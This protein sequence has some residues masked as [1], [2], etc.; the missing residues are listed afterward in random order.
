MDTKD[1][2]RSYTAPAHRALTDLSIPQD[3]REEVARLY[4]YD[5]ID[6]LD[7]SGSAQYQP[8][9]TSVKLQQTIESYLIDQCHCDQVETY[10]RVDDRLADRFALD[11]IA[12]PTL[13]N[14]VAPEKSHLRSTLLTGLYEVVARNFRQDD[15]IQICEIAKV[16]HGQTELTALGLMIYRKSADQR[17][18]D[19]RLQLKGIV[20]GLCTHADMIDISYQASHLSIAHPY[21]QADII[22]SGN[23]IG[24]LYQ[25]HPLTYLDDKIPQT[26][27]IIYAE[28][29]LDHISIQSQTSSFHTLEDPLYTKELC[30]IIPQGSDTSILS[31]KHIPEVL[32]YR[33][34]DVY[35]LGDTKSM[36]LSYH[37]KSDT[38]EQ[39]MDRMIADA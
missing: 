25:L 32:Q 9:T 29:I 30:F 7:L 13:L 6:G 3:V 36:T 24:S 1:D 14:P 26:S 23:N 28:L 35:D 18:D 39:I 16:R 10:I 20:D 8:L 12:Q 15:Q 38:P 2:T 27:Q 17:S 19:S 5:R 37:I 22:Q 31:M 21:K 34:Y 33:L 11:M 4:G